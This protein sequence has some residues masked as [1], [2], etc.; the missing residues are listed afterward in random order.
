MNI[1]LFST[2]QTPQFHK[3]CNIYYRHYTSIV[4][5]MDIVQMLQSFQS[6]R[7]ISEIYLFFTK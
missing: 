2:S 1:S 6:V 3:F 5:K 7:E 4:G